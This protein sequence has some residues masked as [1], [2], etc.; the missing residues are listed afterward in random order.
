MEKI[1]RRYPFGK[2]SCVKWAYRVSFIFLQYTSFGK[3]LTVLVYLNVVNNAKH[4]P[5]R[6]ESVINDDHPKV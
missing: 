6:D 4:G 5:M 1:A 3:M 2:M